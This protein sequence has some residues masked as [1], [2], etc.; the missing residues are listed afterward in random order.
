MNRIELLNNFYQNKLSVDKCISELKM[1]ND[2]IDGFVIYGTGPAGTKLKSIMDRLGLHVYGFINDF[3]EEEEYLET[4]VFKLAQLIDTDKKLCYILTP[5]FK[6]DR[7]VMEEK[8]KQILNREVD[9]IDKNVLFYCSHNRSIEENNGGG[10]FQ[11]IDFII[12]NCCTLNCKNCCVAIPYIAK[13]EKVHFPIEQLKKEISAINEIIDYSA[14]LEVMGGEPL[15]Y[16]NL[17]ELINHIGTLPNIYQMLIDTNGTLVPSEEVFDAIIK[18]DVIVHI[19]DYGD[20]SIKKEELM[21]KCHEKGIGVTIRKATDITWDD[22]GAIVDRKTGDYQFGQCFSKFECSNIYKG[23]W[24]ICPRSAKFHDMELFPIDDK[25]FLDLLDQSSL[26]SKKEKMR[27]LLARKES[28]QS[29]RF[30]S[31]LV[32]KVPAGKQGEQLPREEANR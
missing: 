19:T 3:I 13:S 23:R 17:A 14:V 11:K 29:C 32:D 10:I 22:Y 31:G 9:I 16:P 2:E 26:E 1:L 7:D 18:N 25:E 28:L 30:C 5:H 6:K 12:S 24:H 20:L 21:Q 8:M 27:S 15:L 4:K